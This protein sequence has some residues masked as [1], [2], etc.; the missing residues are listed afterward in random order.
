MCWNNN[1]WLIACI[2]RNSCDTC[3]CCHAPGGCPEYADRRGVAG[4][5]PEWV[6]RLR[7]RSTR[8]ENVLSARRAAIA[9][10]CLE[11]GF[12]VVLLEYILVVPTTVHPKG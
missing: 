7:P 3:Y 12:R 8:Q 5:C 11:G 9:N 1:L 4:E 6:L 10:T 2:Q